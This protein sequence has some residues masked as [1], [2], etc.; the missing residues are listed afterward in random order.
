MIKS[1]RK[2]WSRHIALMERIGMHVGYCWESEKGK[3]H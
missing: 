3:D 1:R 2:I